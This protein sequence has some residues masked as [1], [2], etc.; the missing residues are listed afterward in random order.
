[1]AKKIYEKPE[2]DGV[3]TACYGRDGCDESSKETSNTKKVA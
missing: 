2:I 3:L 1:M